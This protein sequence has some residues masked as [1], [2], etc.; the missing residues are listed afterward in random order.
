MT[1]KLFAGL[2]ILF[3]GLFIQFWFASIG[4]HFDLSFATLISFAFIFDFWEL[5]VLISL[6][7]FIVNWEPSASIEI[8]IFGLYPIAVYFSKH[9]VRWQLW[10]ENLA[11]ILLGFL[12]LYAAASRGAVD[13]HAFAVDAASGM[14]FGALVLLPLYRWGAG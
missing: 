6:A 8:L 11:A 7:V 1:L 4:W 9:V 14:L 10:L 5:L 3:I 13:W 2:F 12:L